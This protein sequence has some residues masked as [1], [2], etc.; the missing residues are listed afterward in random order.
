MKVLII[1]SLLSLILI[2]Q[3]TILDDIAKLRTDLYASY[4]KEDTRYKQFKKWDHIK[5]LFPSDI[6]FNFVDKKNSARTAYMRQKMK[7]DDENMFV[8]SFVLYGLIEAE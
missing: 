2:S 8:T 3:S 6:H 7:I 4:W 1:L 5:G